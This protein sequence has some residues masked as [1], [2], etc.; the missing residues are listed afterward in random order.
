[1][2]GRPKAVGVTS[3]GVKAHHGTVAADPSVFPI[4]T[5][6]DIPGYGAGTVEDIGGAV[7]GRHIDVWFASHDEAV[8]W[9]SRWLKVEAVASNPA[10]QERGKAK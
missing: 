6:L 10:K 7:K 2:K 4:G 5:K 8:K 3:S 1:M 9:G